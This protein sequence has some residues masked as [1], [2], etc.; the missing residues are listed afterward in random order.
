MG[1]IWSMRLTGEQHGGRLMKRNI[2]EPMKIDLQFYDG[3]LNVEEPERLASGL[4]ASTQIERWYIGKDVERI[5]IREGRIQA[6][7]FV[8]KG[9]TLL[10]P[11]CNEMLRQEKRVFSRPS[12]HV[13]V[14]METVGQ[15]NQLGMTADGSLHP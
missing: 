7:L 9:R 1:F 8:P 4:L 6:T 11:G 15:T 2:L 12:I 10:V 13:A 3:H 5:D 14:T